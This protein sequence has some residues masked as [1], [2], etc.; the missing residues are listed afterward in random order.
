MSTRFLKRGVMDDIYMQSLDDFTKYL[1]P[2]YFLY[3]CGGKIGKDAD[4]SWRLEEAALNDQLT[5]VRDESEEVSRREWQ[6]A[7]AFAIHA[8]G[9]SHTIRRPSDVRA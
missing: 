8:T 6:S 3:I 4:W 5:G 9:A 1:F 2:A 7:S